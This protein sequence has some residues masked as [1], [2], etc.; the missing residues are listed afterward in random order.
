MN[1]NLGGMAR[2]SEAI[3]DY[4]KAIYSLARQ[5]DGTA[6]TNALAERLGVTPASV[7]AMV[8][9]LD[10]RG[11]VRHVRYKGVALT[12]DGERVALEIMRHHRL[13]ETYLAEHLG[14][15]W[16]RVHEEAEALEHVLSEYLEARIAAKLGHPTHDP[17]GDPIP[18]AELEIVEEDSRRLSE[19]EPGDCGTFVRVSDSD[20][21]MLRYLDER[22]VK[23]GDP[24][25]VLERQPFDGPLTVRFGDKLHVF[26]GT[27]AH[28]MRVVATAD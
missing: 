12:P 4:A 21:A 16:D 23:L 18:T 15:P 5:G 6:T 17:H 13:L 8:K 2:P 24:L 19:L 11:L 1:R 10:E 14:V 28:A 25:E 7:S 22:G 20:P 26:G 3:E 27:L 9:K